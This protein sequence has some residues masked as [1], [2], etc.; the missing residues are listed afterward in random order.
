[1][2]LTASGTSTAPAWTASLT[3]R[4]RRVIR[5]AVLAFRPQADETRY[6]VT[7]SE[8]YAAWVALAGASSPNAFSETSLNAYTKTTV[9][10]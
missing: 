8:C 1:M 5:D 7:E 2:K 3:E 10:A 6:N 4:E 9:S